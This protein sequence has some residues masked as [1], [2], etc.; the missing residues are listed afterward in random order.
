MAGKH[1]EVPYVKGVENPTEASWN[2]IRWLVK[3]GYS[4]KDIEKVV[5]G[6]ALRVLKEVW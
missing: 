4:D 6:N 2:P 1:K 3:H 5:G